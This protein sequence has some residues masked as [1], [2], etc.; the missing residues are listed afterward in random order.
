MGI[1]PIWFY[2]L[3]SSVSYHCSRL[4]SFSILSDFLGKCTKVKGIFLYPVWAQCTEFPIY[5]SL[6]DEIFLVWMAQ[7]TNWPGNFPTKTT[8][9]FFYLMRV[10]GSHNVELAS[11]LTE[12]KKPMVHRKIRSLPNSHPPTA[13][14][15]Q[16]RIHPP[17]ENREPTV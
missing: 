2:H 10:K 15:N 14:W 12:K 13:Q 5:L 7:K 9:N 11:D 6:F 1:F 3:Q 4:K 17:Q 8:V 16:L